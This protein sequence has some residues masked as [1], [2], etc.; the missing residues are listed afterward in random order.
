MM[1][2]DIDDPR[3]AGFVST[4]PDATL[5]HH[6]A[7]STAI[8]RCYDY[9][10]FAFALEDDSGRVRAGLPLVE[11][12]TR[13]G[14]RRWI[15]LPFTDHCPPLA[16]EAPDRIRLIVEL[17]RF[18]VS[19][20]IEELE[21]RDDLNHGK[22]H[23]LKA[24]VRHSLTIRPDV[25][26]MFRA[27]HRSQVQRSIVK[28]E[29][30]RIEVRVAERAEDLT[31]VFY[32]LHANTRRRLGVPVQPRRFFQSVWD[33]TI[34]RDLAFVLIACAAGV[35]VA[36]AVFLSWNGTLI[37]KY[38]ASDSTSWNLRP[39]HAL[40]WNAIQWAANNGYHTLDFGRTEADQEGL[41]N[42]K[43]GW[44][45]KEERLQYSVLSDRA[46]RESR[47]RLSRIME[48]V[49]KRSPLWVTKLVGEWGYKYAA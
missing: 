37:Y 42:F 35:P 1:V 21:V 26:E 46:P 2:L 33:E 11:V 10:P 38:G 44:G 43:S 22:S 27:F 45:A 34:E 32:R 14:R 23:P 15:S 25:Q 17:D 30:E 48:P 41:R 7:W 49:I 28:S 4:C 6:P 47:Q 40:F 39:N 13:F 24:A 20:G 8:S 36:S 19:E 9:K 31:D 16:S 5:F 18:R 3:W 29:R 12:R